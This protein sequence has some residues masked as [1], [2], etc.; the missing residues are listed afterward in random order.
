V[1]SNDQGTGAPLTV[2]ALT[3]E[4]TLFLYSTPGPDGEELGYEAD[5]ILFPTILNETAKNMLTVQDLILEGGSGTTGQIRNPH[6]QSGMTMVRAPELTGTASTA[7]WYLLSL[8]AIAAGLVPWVMSE[9]GTEDII[10]WDETS[11][12]TKDSGF[13]KYESQVRLSCC[14]LYP[15]AIRLVNGT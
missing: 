13:I 7:N 15:H 10:V 5:C 1:W 4:K 6:F 12:F 8:A 3:A 2:A 9:D 14:L 11:D